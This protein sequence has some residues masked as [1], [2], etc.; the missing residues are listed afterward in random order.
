MINKTKSIILGGVLMGLLFTACDDNFLELSNPNQ[1]TVDSYW[2]N[3]ADVESALTGTYALLQHQWWD[4]F[5]AP[6]EM[7]MTMEVLSDLT[8]ADIFSPISDHKSYNA[9]STAYT[10]KYF[11]ETN[12]KMIFAAN[13]VI[14]NVPNVPN[15]TEA[16]KTTFIAEAKFLRAYA[17]FQTLQLYGNIIM[18]NTVPG[19]PEK[20]YQGQSTPQE[21]YAFIEEDL[22]AAKTGLPTSWESKWLGRA[23]KGAAIAYLGKVYLTQEKWSNAETEFKALTGMG[24]GLV[25][26]P[27]SLFNGLNEFSEES[28]FEINYS[29][30]RPGGRIESQSLVPNFNSWR[31]LWPTQHLKDLF[32]AD[33]TSAGNP[34]KRTF[35][36]IVFNHPDSDV[37]YFDGKTFA[38]YYG[39]DDEKIYYKKYD[40]YKK[41]ED[42]YKF[43][44]V[45]SNFVMM[46]YADVLLMLAEAQNEQGNSSEALGYVNQ[47]RTRAGSVLLSS[48]MSQADLRNHIREIERP[49]E[50][51]NET[52]RFFDLVRW[53]KGD[54]GVQAA[55][56]KNN[57]PKWDQFND[58]VD[59]IWPIPDKEIKANP[60]V[61]QNAGY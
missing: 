61:K 59:E 27:Y 20:F 38:E 1:M 39:A 44:S 21:V 33:T 34:S 3:A 53:Y 6:G 41:G 13:Q 7:F 48:G 4:S 23:T 18:V 5:W 10:V 54:G 45:G 49:L 24:Y 32:M 30:N 16:Q 40:Y 52:T 19:S 43:Y 17:H 2:R 26:D 55:I 28:I 25:D 36:S 50:L 9:S 37:W 35:A 29:A 14:E 46:R 42:A 47:V 11:W 31:G 60:Q 57:G 56:K 15:L 58:G 8:N 51:C 12:Y 22:T